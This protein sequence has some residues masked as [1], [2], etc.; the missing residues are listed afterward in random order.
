MTTSFDPARSL[1]AYRYDDAS[2]CWL[3]RDAVHDW[4]YSDGEAVE[5]NLFRL[6]SECSDRSVLSAELAEKI[7][8][9]PT[10][11]YF[12]SRRA[13]LLRPLAGLLRG[14]VLEI[15]AGCGAVTRYLG[16]TARQVVAIEPSPRRARVAAK[17]C[18]DL[19]NVHV[20][21]ENL[22]AF[23]APATFDVVTLI[24][25]LEYA[26][27]F[28]GR[29]DAAAHWLQ[30]ARRLLKPGGV[31]LVAIENQLGLKYFAGAPEDHLGRP[32]L[33]LADLYGTSGARTYGRAALEALLADAGFAEVGF[34]LPFPD[35]KLPTSVLL[36]RGSDAMPGFDGGAALA[37]ASTT[38]DPQMG[39]PPVFAI[40]RTWRVM[41][42][43]DLLPE[44]SN[45]FLAVAHMQPGNALY[46]A[47]N[48]VTSAYHFST[49]RAPIFAKQA[50]FEYG[51]GGSW[52]RRQFLV[53][54]SER[55]NLGFECHPVDESYVHGR[56]I[57]SDLYELLLSDGW[58]IEDVGAWV[59]RWLDAVAMH[60]G[61]GLDA[62]QRSFYSA[63]TMLPGD[64]I[65]LVPHNLV[66]GK[67]GEPRFIDLEW[68]S[69]APVSLGFLAFRGLLEV[70]AGCVSVARPYDPRHV[71]GAAFIADAMRHGG[72]ELLLLDTDVERYL[73]Q[74]RTFQRA[75]SNREPDLCVATF[76]AM[77]MPVSTASQVEGPLSIAAESGELAMHFANLQAHHDALNAEHET[78]ATWGKGLDIE[79]DDLRSRYAALVQ[80]HEEVAT[81]A[82]N[83]DEQVAF[84]SDRL[85]TLVQLAEN[86]GDVNGATLGAYMLEVVT[87]RRR[88]GLAER[89]ADRLAAELAA[90]QQSVDPDQGV[91]AALEE[92][93][94]VADSQIG[95]ITAEN[96]RLRSD[97][98]RSRQRI[99]N[100]ERELARVR[101][102]LA[103]GADDERE[104]GDREAGS[105]ASDRSAVAMA[106]AAA[107][108]A[109]LREIQVADDL[110]RSLAR[111][112]DV[113]RQL[114]MVRQQFDQVVQ[115]QSW[116]FTRPLR[117]AMRL[118]RRDWVG[119]SDSLRGQAWVQS[120]ALR[121]IREPAKRFLMGRRRN[122]T[123]MGGLV[124]Q[125]KVD[126]RQLLDGVAFTE[127]DAPLVSIIIPAYG[128]LDHT[129]ACV[130]SI[131]DNLPSVTVEI[132]VA[133]DASGDVEIGEL[134]TV[135]G[136]RYYENPTNLGFLRS[137]NHAATLARG[138]YL[139]FLNND[140]EVTA[141][142]LDALVHT[143][144]AWPDCG[145]AGSKLVYPDGRQQEAGGIIW[146]DA[147]AWNYGR[148][149]DPS[150]SIYNY[151]REVDYIS[152]ASIMLSRSLFDSFGG[153]DEH[154]L[155]AYFEDT[156][157]A[158]K[159]RDAGLKVVFE[160]RSVVVHY[161]G[162]SHGTDTGQGIK[163]YQVE[164]QR[165]FHER[166][167]EVLER[168]HLA[169]A[170]RPFLARDRASL[171]KMVL[172]VDH[173]I[174]QPDQ[175]AGSRAMLQLMEVLRAQG[176]A[177]KFWPQ[178]LWEDRIYAPR[179]QAM[180]VEVVYGGE[181]LG[182]FK[183]W[184]ADFGPYLDAVILSRPH[185]A[186][187]FLA[188]VRTRTTCPVLYYGHDIHHLRLIEQ[189]SITPSDEIRAEAERFRGMEERLWRDVDAI[190]YPSDDE[191]AYVEA[192]AGTHGVSVRASTIPLNAFADVPTSVD[193]A[194]VERRD[195]LFVGGFGH[196]P[197]ADGAVWFVNEVLPLVRA[198]HPA[199]RLS[200]VGSRPTPE[201]R[202]LASE[203]VEVTDFVPD[204]ELERRYAHARVVVA[205]LR[206][207][208][209]MKG[210]VVEAMRFGVPCV[211]TP[212]GAQ[213]FG[214]ADG[215]LE[216]ASA[217]DAF[218]SEII[219]LLEDDARWR[220]RSGRGL[221]FVR[222]RFSYAALWTVLA[223]DV[224]ASREGKDA[225]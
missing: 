10:R 209:G 43:N 72:T 120:R 100:L 221:A 46:G 47:E 195:L 75:V 26:E 169:N 125:A 217:P 8:D 206:F 65:D 187:E 27:R 3:R 207:G 117:F 36:S 192:W 34:A 116:R 90:M 68:R 138:Q 85:D 137:C 148:L 22:E 201:V 165:K 224:R 140:T 183:D 161:E 70:V 67:D 174:P 142:W 208:G 92:R 86:D 51:D 130:R 32:M 37:A 114:G 11:Y 12:S 175:D 59:R 29:P 2:L 42:D 52:V 69:L 214:T 81:W 57:T 106:E 4:A 104:R 21:V 173:Y 84:A 101:R 212:T 197:N 64:A 215:A 119:V 7:T 145:M 63:E 147:S 168:D 105:L 98:D 118:M 112:G 219:A 41:A 79:L 15:G 97:I 66:Q 172:I 171:G 56:S 136:L 210:K 95:E 167:R 193:G 123:A 93:A 150:R 157:L 77:R 45:S 184:I 14:D 19:D 134:A 185:V 146:K 94:S 108:A 58:A 211:T 48:A 166:W 30:C 103:G 53:P 110:A 50:T 33:G 91:R 62:L 203:H 196:P 6:V 80:E 111:L 223:N 156:D 222:E 25:V 191:T 186:T 133:E 131:F 139:Y 213:G 96:E 44:F 178:N 160:P 17:R 190:Y 129:A 61:I 128:R 199:V 89:R 35:Y 164:N 204:E 55:V 82:R 179:L 154:Y 216:V 144:R 20:V 205:P 54:A 149:D 87:L 155:P 124:A 122:V 9:W 176:V 5:E 159:V 115:S 38:R 132:I 73:E 39:R 88:S 181:H 18:E 28:A 49:E 141:G 78:V 200:L 99:L 153:F 71:D 163:A 102:V 1:A 218:A 76:R 40:D 13:N 180:G 198:R 135:P 23:G 109:R 152:G 162:I 189:A 31:L 113:E 60:T 151:T 220:D 194:L 182:R 74:E 16:E 202:A 143:M 170:D 158:M 107:A 126:P 127:V 188:E 83:L 177:V 24:G 121:V 225:S